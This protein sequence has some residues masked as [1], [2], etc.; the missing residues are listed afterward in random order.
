[1]TDGD[2]CRDPD[3]AEL[4]VHHAEQEVAFVAL[5]VIVDKPPELIVL[6]DAEIVIDGIGVVLT[7]TV[8]EPEP[9]PPAP[10]HVIE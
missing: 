3:V 7:V 8:A 6:G 5:Q 10:L 4:P 2:T 9:E 1:M